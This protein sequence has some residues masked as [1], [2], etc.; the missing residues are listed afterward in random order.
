[1][2]QFPVFALLTLYIQAKSTW[3]NL[4]SST[5]QNRRQTGQG[6][7]RSGRLHEVKTTKQLTI[8]DCQVGFPIRTSRDQRVLS[9]PPGLSQSATSFIAS[10][11]QGIH[12]TPLSRLI[13]SRRRRALLPGSGSSANPSLSLDQKSRPGSTPSAGGA[14]FSK[15]R[16]IQGDQTKLTVSVIRLGKTVLV[17]PSPRQA[18]IRGLHPLTTPNARTRPNPHSGRTQ[19]VSCFALFTMSCG[20]MSP[21]GAVSLPGLAIRQG[22]PRHGPANLLVSKGLVGRGGVEPPLPLPRP[23]PPSNSPPESSIR[24]SPD[25]LRSLTLIR[26]AL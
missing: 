5:A 13:R 18:P 9:P 25:R 14:R 2:F 23:S 3:F 16:T 8:E 24:L 21:S 10:C 26:R 7:A 19:N 15:L 6:P 12:Q 11:C 17:V 20:R 1:M 22:G 4:R